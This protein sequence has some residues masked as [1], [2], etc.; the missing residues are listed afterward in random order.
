MSDVWDEIGLKEPGFT[1]PNRIKNPPKIYMH[2]SEEITNTRRAKNLEIIFKILPDATFLRS[3]IVV[4][5][6]SGKR[7]EFWPAS[8]TWYSE[9][10]HQFGVGIAE[11]C[12]L[13]EKHLLQ[14]V[15]TGE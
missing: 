9:S 11:L 7:F 4:A 15:V 12:Q 10:K 8:D 5:I 3:S 2:E 6:V 1:I 14:K 13:I